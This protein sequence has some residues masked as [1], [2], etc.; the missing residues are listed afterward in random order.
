MGTPS[1]AVVDDDPQTGI[2]YYK[3][4]VVMYAYP[5]TP[6]FGWPSNC[7]PGGDTWR[8]IPI[9]SGTPTGTV[10]RVV[11]LAMG[12]S[13]FDRGIAFTYDDELIPVT[14]YHANYVGSAG[15][16]GFDLGPGG[17]GSFEWQ[18]D[19]L[20]GY[21]YLS[22]GSTPSF[23]IDI[24]PENYSVIAY[25]YRMDDMGNNDLYIVYP[26]ARIDD[27]DPGWTAQKIDGAP[28]FD[29]ETGAQASLALSSTGMGFISYLQEEAYELDDLKIAF[30]LYR[31][32]LPIVS[33][34]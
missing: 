19:D 33:K 29:V 9:F 12:Q 3:N 20:I 25:N 8:C 7:G 16:C 2:A 24:D 13:M 23:S 6:V 4:G 34:P 18:C 5:H 22:A 28:V 30:Q 32:T 26:N 1:L 17:D 11:K 31:A 27:P 15:D 14:L 21:D 10:G